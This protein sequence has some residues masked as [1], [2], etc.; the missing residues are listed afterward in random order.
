MKN[1]H[2]VFLLI[3]LGCIELLFLSNDSL[4]RLSISKGSEIQKKSSRDTLPSTF[5]YYSDRFIG[6]GVFFYFAVALLGLYL[7][8]NKIGSLEMSS[9]E[10][11]I[12]FT[13]YCNYKELSRITPLVCVLRV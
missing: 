1:G 7:W 12:C 2:K 9:K 10:P 13:S 8:V 5:G 6:I 3:S 4:R 11:I